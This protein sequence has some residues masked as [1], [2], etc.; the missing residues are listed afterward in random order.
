M[1]R[2]QLALL[3][4]IRLLFW[5]S[6]SRF[7][8]RCTCK[9]CKGDT[10]S[11]W[12]NQLSEGYMPR[13]CASSR[14]LQLTRSGNQQESPRFSMVIAHFKR[15]GRQSLRL[16]WYDLVALETNVFNLNSSSVWN[17]ARSTFAACPGSRVAKRKK[18]QSDFL[19]P[20]KHFITQLSWTLIQ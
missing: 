5:A 19:G 14:L 4:P 11:T 13:L 3:H 2:E 7:Q 6:A 10:F 1:C 20:A 9:H 12:A 15:L 17:V 16:P 8:R 18:P